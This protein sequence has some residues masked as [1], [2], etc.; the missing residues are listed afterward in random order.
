M[1]DISLIEPLC[2]RVEQIAHQNKASKVLRIVLEVGEDF[3][4]SPDHFQ[5]TYLML[6][7]QTPLLR[8]AQLEF[9]KVSGI[10]G[11]EMVLRDVELEVPDEK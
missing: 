8:D 9:R 11:H 10:H 1:H 2:D 3:D 4:F 6:S 7:G 5:E